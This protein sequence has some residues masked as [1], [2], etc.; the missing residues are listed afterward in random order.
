MKAFS[1]LLRGPRESFQWGPDQQ[2]AFDEIKEAI[3]TPPVL[4]PPRAGKP[5]KLYIAASDHSIGCLLSQ[6]DEAE[7]EQVV[8]YLSKTLNQVEER[9]SPIEKL[10]LSLYYAC[11]KLEHYMMPR[12]VH[13]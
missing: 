1:V 5:L 13:V 12:V 9:Y 7:K 6:D 2:H 11:T 10:C 3:A 4:M 8:Y